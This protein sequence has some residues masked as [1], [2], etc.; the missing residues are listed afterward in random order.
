MASR[1]DQ[2]GLL[3]RGDTCAC[4]PI[5]GTSAQAYFNED[6]RGGI[7]GHQVDLAKT[8][9]IV[10]LQNGQTTVSKEIRGQILRRL[11]VAFQGAKTL[12]TQKRMAECAS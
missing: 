4:A 7:P 2:L 1:A 12:G 9:A 6:E 10:A 8:A 11:C 3:R 5:V